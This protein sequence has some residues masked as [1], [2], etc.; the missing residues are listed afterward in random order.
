MVHYA[1][2][3]MAGGRSA[4]TSQ[5]PQPM[6]IG[7]VGGKGNKHKGDEGGK[8]HGKG[9]EQVT[10]K[11]KSTFKH[12]D[13]SKKKGYCHSCGSLAHV[14]FS[15]SKHNGLFLCLRLSINAPCL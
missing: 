10:G 13:E 3:Q 7:F 4:A 12:G 2:L 11:G 14:W 5:P 15:Y 1:Q 9:K 8:S 6:D